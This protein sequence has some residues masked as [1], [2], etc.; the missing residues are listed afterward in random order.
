M[1]GENEVKSERRADSVG[2]PVLK[3]NSGKHK[4]AMVK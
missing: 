3:G 4:M 1:A 2:A